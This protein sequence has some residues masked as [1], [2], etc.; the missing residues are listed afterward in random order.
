MQQTQTRKQVKATRHRFLDMHS[1][2]QI[3]ERS[4]RVGWQKDLGSLYS[5]RVTFYNNVLLT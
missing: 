3:S 2:R 4:T 1:H 5:G